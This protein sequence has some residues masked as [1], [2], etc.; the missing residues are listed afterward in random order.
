MKV[1]YYSKKQIALL[2]ALSKYK[3]LTYDQMMRLGI[4]KHKSNLSNIANK[5][6][7]CRY[8]LIAKIPHQIGISAKHYLTAKGK[9]LLVN[10]YDLEEIKIRYP[11][12]VIQTHTQ[13]TKHRTTTV[14]ILIELALACQERSIKILEYDFYFDMVGNNR[15]AKN[16]ASK[17][18][19]IYEG[20]KTI[21]ADLIFQLQIQNERELYLL[22]LENGRDTKKA[23]EKIINHG[24]AVYKGSANKIYQFKKGYRTLWVFEYES[25]LKA[26]LERAK[27]ISF[28]SQ[29]KEYFLFKTLAEIEKENFFS[30]WLNLA[31]IKRKLYYTKVG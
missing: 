25:T 30:E 23:I 20:N 22:E 4:D 3:F 29:L 2:I 5:L 31:N 13:D 24:K 28:F 18:A 27:K 19:L 26:T 21:K 14:S 15:M 17:T 11:K 10:L 16:L 7:A 8:P 9:D 1:N 12:G 6:R